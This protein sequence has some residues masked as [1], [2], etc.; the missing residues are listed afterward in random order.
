MIER[1]LFVQTNGFGLR[2]QASKNERKWFRSSL[3]LAKLARRTDRRVKILKRPST[4]LSHEALV[5]GKWKMTRGV[6]ASQSCTSGVLCVDEVSR[7]TCRSPPGEA[8]A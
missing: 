4:T 1:A 8:R 6:S 3:R 7:R 5:G 2:F